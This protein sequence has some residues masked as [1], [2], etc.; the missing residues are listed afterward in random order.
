MSDTISI[1]LF[2][3]L[4]KYSPENSQDYPLKPEMNIS[5]LIQELKLP[6]KLVKLVF[7]NGVKSNWD[8]PLKDGDRL[9]VFPPVGGG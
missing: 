1:N 6:E 4:S 7:L 9:G 5:L 3:T 8:T 2:A